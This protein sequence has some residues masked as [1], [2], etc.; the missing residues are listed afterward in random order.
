[1]KCL[2]PNLPG[3]LTL[4]NN[5]RD[6]GENYPTSLG[7]YARLLDGDLLDSVKNVSVDHIKNRQHPQLNDLERSYRVA[8]KDLR[9]SL[10]YLPALKELVRWQ[11]DLNKRRVAVVGS[12]SS[13][14]FSTSSQAIVKGSLLG[15]LA[16]SW[17]LS[18]QWFEHELLPSYDGRRYSSRGIPSLTV[19]HWVE[20]MLMLEEVLHPASFLLHLE[21]NP[22]PRMMETLSMVETPYHHI[23]I[24]RESMVAQ[25]WKNQNSTVDRAGFPWEVILTQNLSAT[26][27]KLDAI[28]C[29]VLYLEL[30]NPTYLHDTIAMLQLPD[31]IEYIL[32]I[33]E[34]SSAP[35]SIN[36]LFTLWNEDVEAFE[37]IAV[38]YL[39]VKQLCDV[40][41]VDHGAVLYR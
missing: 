17:I 29:I 40:S 9:W 39:A 13:F 20:V 32:L 7:A 25:T 33:D 27:S 5:Y 26:S 2:Y 4:V 3:N 35:F 6:A 36:V 1:M 14:A 15:S 24:T 21:S 31:P 34:C 28:S 30:I 37:K 18:H 19:D 22:L 38:E 23:I 10:H 11:F 12:T 16:K 8:L 41:P